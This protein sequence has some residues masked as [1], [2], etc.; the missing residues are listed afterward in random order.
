MSQI[1]SV[2]KSSVKMKLNVLTL[3]IIFFDYSTQIMCHTKKELRLK[4]LQLKNSFCIV[5]YIFNT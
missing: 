2:R 3:L 5:A 4:I 1:G